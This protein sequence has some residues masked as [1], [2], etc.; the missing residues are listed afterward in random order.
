[1]RVIR[2]RRQSLTPRELQVMG[3]DPSLTSTGWACAGEV[4]RLRS[5]FKGGQRF[6]HL[7]NQFIALLE[8]YKPDVIFYEGY[9]FGKSMPGTMARAEL[10]GLF[11]AEA[12]LRGIPVV[13][14]PPTCLKKAT[15][16]AG[17]AKKPQMKSSIVSLFGVD[18]TCNDD[19]IDAYALYAL[20]V[21]LLLGRGPAGFVNRA[22]AATEKVEIV[23]GKG[24]PEVQTIAHLAS[25]G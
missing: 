3:I 16:N 20:G 12:Y 4:G 17:N 8:H 24:K 22:K 5:K 25:V 2:A 10:G 18:S 23:T 15:T 14:V 11:K 19:E 6:E 21:A 7:R 13:L 9:A 1:M